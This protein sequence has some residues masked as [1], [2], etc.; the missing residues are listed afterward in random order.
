MSPSTKQSS[1]VERG[2]ERRKKKWEKGLDMGEM[3]GKGGSCKQKVSGGGPWSQRD[4]F[5]FFFFLPC[6]RELTSSLASIPV[7]DCC[8]DPVPYWILCEWSLYCVELCVSLT[9]DLHVTFW[10]SFFKK[11]KNSENNKKM[12]KNKVGNDTARKEGKRIGVE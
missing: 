4:I 3:E 10:N 9:D 7:T 5:F 6:Q 2:G 12:L 1:Q 11:K 8:P